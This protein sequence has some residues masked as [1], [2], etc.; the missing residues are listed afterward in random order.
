MQTNQ[1]IYCLAIV[2]I[3]GIS[4]LGENFLMGLHVVFDRERLILGGRTPNVS[5]LPSVI[6]SNT[7]LV[8]KTWVTY[9]ACDGS[10][11][12]ADNSTGSS[13][14][15]APAP[16]PGGCTRETKAEGSSSRVPVVSPLCH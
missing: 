9:R 4:I 16:S 15:L 8:K 12:A 10:G 6:P 3:S 7:W 11:Y 2:K 1:S 14:P 5:V 13:P